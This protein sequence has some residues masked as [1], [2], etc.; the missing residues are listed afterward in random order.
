MFFFSLPMVV[1]FFSVLGFGRNSAQFSSSSSPPSNDPIEQ[2]LVDDGLVMSFDKP[3]LKLALSQEDIN[4]NEIKLEALW[5]G[6]SKCV[7][8]DRNE[9]Q[10]TLVY[11]SEKG[12]S[13]VMKWS[14]GYFFIANEVEGLPHKNSPIEITLSDRQ[15]IFSIAGGTP[16][17]TSLCSLGFQPKKDAVQASY[18]EFSV[19]NVKQVCKLQ[20]KFDSR[21]QVYKPPD[22]KN[23]KKA[24]NNGSNKVILIVC[25]SVGAVCVTLIMAGVIICWCN[26]KNKKD[27]HPEENKA[28]DEEHVMPVAV[29]CVDN[30]ATAENT[31]IWTKTPTIPS[32][33]K[34]F[35]K[36]RAKPTQPPETLKESAKKT[37]HQEKVKKPV[38]PQAKQPT[39]KKSEVK[40]AELPKIEPAIEKRVAVLK[41]KSTKERF[42]VMHPA[43][44]EH[45]ENPVDTV[46]EIPEEDNDSNSPE[47]V[48][49]F[50]RVKHAAIREHGKKL[51]G[52]EVKNLGSGPSG[53][54]PRSVMDRTQQDSLKE[55]PICMGKS[56]YQCQKSNNPC[57][58]SYTNVLFYIFIFLP[59]VLL[60]CLSLDGAQSDFDWAFALS[61]KRKS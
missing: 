42:M 40:T 9:N 47:T 14:D 39:I 49:V 27:G 18:A 2:L 28:V 10:L 7:T 29:T 37:V 51:A 53:D 58:F 50:S 13:I 17:T 33:K 20:L 19:D 52:I 26:K 21:Y 12:C 54:W 44:R 55:P 61:D 56:K 5:S 8:A 45:V 16:K 24:E 23:S 11:G 25:I 38:E 6:S 34:R 59:N 46:V 36:T 41:K 22:K 30:V 35:T 3:N 4:S 57:A 32:D 1:C 60:L 15:A 43:I 48:R 31:H